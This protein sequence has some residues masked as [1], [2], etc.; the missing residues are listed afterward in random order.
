MHG[1]VSHVRAVRRRRIRLRM[2]PPVWPSPCPPCCSPKAPLRRSHPPADVASPAQVRWRGMSRGAPK[3][4]LFFLSATRK[5]ATELSCPLGTPRAMSMR[6]GGDM[7]T[8]ATL[9][10]HAR[11][12]TPAL[13]PSTSCTP[14][15]V[16]GCGPA[17]QCDT[18]RPPSQHTG[19]Q[20]PFQTPHGLGMA[21][22]RWRIM[23]GLDIS[24]SFP[25][26]DS[27]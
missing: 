4:L 27:W 7:Y 23:S 19:A 16:R 8:A 10:S 9:M 6:T 22:A 5:F 2:C 11:C 14:E 15:S 25:H 12:A 1:L 26:F 20:T 24:F 3:S 17:P 21:R 18:A 13:D